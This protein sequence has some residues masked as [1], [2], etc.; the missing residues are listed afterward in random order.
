MLNKGNLL[1]VLLLG[2]ALFSFAQKEE[3]P[4]LAA[5]K[6]YMY[7]REMSGGIKLQTNGI[8]GYLEYGLIK[9]I[10]K[11]HLFQIEYQYYIDFKEKKI[12]SPIENG[13]DYYF[14][15]QNRFHI[16]RASYGFERAIADKA[17]KNG[18]RL[19]FVGFVG[20][21]L[22][23]AKPYYLN[24]LYENNDVVR[25]E[26][27][28]STNASVF[29]DKNRITEAAS[30]TKGISETQPIPG[31]HLKLGLNFDWGSRDAFVKAIEA[32]ALIDVYYKKVPVMVNNDT[33]RMF[34]LGLY[35]GF[36]FGKRW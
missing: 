10:Y 21:T 19:S 14:G 16:I 12:K 15:L 26:K 24:L 8:S 25:S 6:D 33:N 31:G 23:L 11:T 20:V 4:K 1:L 36:H 32:G 5:V 9:N 2:V 29:L 17:T 35:I 34:Q 28:A 3:N 27:Y 30:S 7:K 18:V 13:R 22:G